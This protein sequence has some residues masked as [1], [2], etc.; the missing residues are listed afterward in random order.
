MLTTLKNDR[1]TVSAESIGAE[2]QA[3]DTAEGISYLWNGDPAHWTGHAPILFPIVGTL[4]EGR[5][6]SAQ[7]EIALPRHGFCRRASF[8]T[9]AATQTAVTYRLSDSEETRR[10]YPYAFRLLVGYELLE[11]GVVTRCRV[12]NTGDKPMPFAI[13]GHPAFRVPLCE[14][15]IFE[16]YRIAF[17]EPE[18]AD[19]PQIDLNTGLLLDGRRNRVLNGQA[20]L[21]LNHG[22]FRGD[23]LVFDALKSRSVRLYSTK[24]GRGVSLDFDGFDYLGIWSPSLDAPFVCLEPWTG[25]ATRAS[26]DDVFEHKLGM[27]EL[28]PGDEKA[29]AF[30]IR[31]F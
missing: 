1:L 27:T 2:L 19:C 21:T 26:E 16:E 25:M 15:E 11:D 7:G 3:I 18:T 31:V 17:P 23:A 5:A 9:E 24:S 13:G 20:E 28:A 30:T 12:K 10:V 6:Q 8:Q 4:R 29:F 22:L 14:G